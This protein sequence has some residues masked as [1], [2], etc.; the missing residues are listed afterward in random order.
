LTSPQPPLCGAFSLA[1]PGL[2]PALRAVFRPP[3]NPPPF[4]GPCFR[5][6]SRSFASFRGQNL[7]P[8]LF[9]PAPSSPVKPR[10][11]PGGFFPNTA[12]PVPRFNAFFACLRVLSQ[13]NSP[14][15]RAGFGADG[16][17]LFPGFQASFAFFR[18]PSRSFADKTSPAR[19]RSSAPCVKQFPATACQGSPSARFP[20]FRLP[21]RPF[22]S[23]CGQP[24]RPGFGAGGG[25]GSP[26]LLRVL[27]RSF[28]DKSPPP[29]GRFPAPVSGFLRVLSRLF[30]DK[31][32]LRPPRSGFGGAGSPAPL[33]VL[34]ADKTSLPNPRPFPGPCVKQ[35]PQRRARG[36][37]PL[38]QAFFAFLRG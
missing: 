16:G 31:T 23:L 25:A 22:A 35:L 8:V 2:Q 12:G 19:R 27:S 14:P 7:P 1:P 29:C 37:L 18:V 30:A 17:A 38:F 32:S 6:P 11:L 20:G 28:A 33:R 13:T 21:L 34:F 24:P 5:L 10:V 26:A 3:P 15:P 4:P 9:R 36:L